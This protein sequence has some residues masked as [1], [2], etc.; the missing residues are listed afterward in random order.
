MPRAILLV[1]DLVGCGGEA[2]CPNVP[3]PTVIPS[4]AQL[5]ITA[6]LSTL[7]SS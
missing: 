2:L 7:R 1:L 3:D 4:A 6:S 5:S